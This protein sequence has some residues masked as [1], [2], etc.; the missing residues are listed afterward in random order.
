MRNK[1]TWL[2]RVQAVL[3][4]IV[5]LL[6]LAVFA[7]GCVGAERGL[8]T[9]SAGHSPALQIQAGLHIGSSN[10]RP[11]Q[12]VSDGEIPGK[13]VETLDLGDVTIT[14]TVTVSSG[15]GG[16]STT[17]S[18]QGEQSPGIEVATEVDAGP[19]P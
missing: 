15:D 19:V 2:E 14:T 10:T 17:A 16:V 4:A 18:D 5:V 8:T 3:V 9:A 13:I 7:T 12:A 1:V 11:L 6:A